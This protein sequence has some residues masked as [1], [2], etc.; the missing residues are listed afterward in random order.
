MVSLFGM[1]KKALWFYVHVSLQLT[2]MAAFITAWII[3]FAELP[4]EDEVSVPSAGALGKAHKGLGIATFV[5]AVV[6]VTIAIVECLSLERR[7]FDSASGMGSSVVIVAGA[8]RPHPDSPKRQYWSTFHWNACDSCRC[9]ASPPRL[10]KR[11][12]WNTFHWNAGRLTMLVAWA[13]LFTG[14]ATNHHPKD[15]QSGMVTHA[16]ILA[17]IIGCILVWDAVLTYKR[18]KKV[19]V[20]VSPDGSLSG[21]KLKEK[22]DSDLDMA[23]VP[24]IGDVSK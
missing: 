21:G 18:S 5:L 13:A 6:Q 11:Q 10:P 9:T 17:A 22:L 2:G 4:W 23:A 1:E 7:P 14:I 20:S 12:Y 19:P 15:Q 24:R 16:V 3:A 8:L